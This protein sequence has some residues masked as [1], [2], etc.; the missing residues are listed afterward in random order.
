MQYIL[1]GSAALEE[2]VGV[3]GC[4]AFVFVLFTKQGRFHVAKHVGVTFTSAPRLHRTRNIRLIETQGTCIFSFDAKLQDVRDPCS[5][6]HFA[7]LSWCEM[8]R[9]EISGSANSS[10]NEGI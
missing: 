9:H 3:A 8:E 10:S 4:Y 7:Q 6:R 2:D 5:E 1:V